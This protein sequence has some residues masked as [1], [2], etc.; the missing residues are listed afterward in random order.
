MNRAAGLAIGAA[1]L[2]VTVGV[3]IG[4]VIHAGQ[5]ERAGASPASEFGSATETAPNS[6]DISSSPTSSSLSGASLDG[7]A[8]GP[9]IVPSDGVTTS[10][11][12][13]TA[14]SSTPLTVPGTPPATTSDSADV[15]TQTTTIEGASADGETC[16]SLA[17]RGADA[18]GTTL[19]CQVDQTDR[20]LRWRAV[21]NGG[22]CLNQ[23]MTGVGADDVDYICRL[24]ASGRNHW[25][26]A[27]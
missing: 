23:T 26:P 11:D 13:Q 6:S 20:T 24:D 2:S 9:E 12:S 8:G 10:D 16:P 22:G 5:V 14:S 1:V 15:S 19:Y 17:V 21:V 7:A 3:L 18:A 25:A 4:I 27:S